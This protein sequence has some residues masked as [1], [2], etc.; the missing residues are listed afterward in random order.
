MAIQI[1]GMCNLYAPIASATMTMIQ[2]A[3]A[4]LNQFNAGLRRGDSA[5]EVPR[6]PEG[7]GPRDVYFDWM[8]NAMTSE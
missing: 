6:G 4:R 2:P 8:M 3:R 1:V 7:P 5:M